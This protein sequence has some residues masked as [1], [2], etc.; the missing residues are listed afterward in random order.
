MHEGTTWGLR[1]NVFL[2]VSIVWLVMAL[3]GL[4]M[5]VLVTKGKLLAR[6]RRRAEDI[7]KAA[8]SVA[9]VAPDR[10]RPPFSLLAFCYKYHY[11]LGLIVVV[12]WLIVIASGI[13]LQVRYELPWAMP[14]LHKG[15][16]GVPTLKFTDALEK[17]RLI[18]NVGIAEWKDVWRVY[19]YPAKGVVSVRAKNHWQVQL[20]ANTGELLDLSVRRTDILED[21][22]EGKWMGA[23][24]WLFLPVHVLSVVLWILGV[25]MGF[26]SI[27]TSVKRRQSK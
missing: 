6:K 11:A 17:A 9:G 21:I 2:W 1:T 14:Q 20:D 12:P 16:K 24:L 18:P 4:Y 3:C 22:H 5:V 7:Q 15:S 23:N 25:I 10:P 27:L 13:L 8:S 26:R 19:V